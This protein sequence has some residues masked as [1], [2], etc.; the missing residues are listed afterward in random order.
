M[1]QATTAA[2]HAEW[3]L[4]LVLGIALVLAL[5]GSLL[6]ILAESTDLF[7]ARLTGAD[8]PLR[9]LFE[10]FYFISQCAL[11]LVAG[12]ALIFAKRQ[13]QEARNARLVSVYAQLEERWSSTQMLLARKLFREIMSKHRAYRASGQTPAMEIAA[14]FECEMKRL[15]AADV[16]TCLNIL[17]LADYLEFIGMLEDNG[18]VD[19]KELEALMGELCVTVHDIMAEHIEGARALNRS[20][21]AQSGYVN[22]PDGYASFSRLAEKFADRFRAPR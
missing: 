9:N 18:F 5:F 20:L 15:G 6:F 17:A 7:A 2:I 19:L 12:I 1:R 11:L 3:Q 8:A 10:L 21:N 13:S 14:F 4:F 16:E 22:V